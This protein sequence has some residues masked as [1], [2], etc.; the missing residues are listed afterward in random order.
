MSTIKKALSKQEWSKHCRIEL[1]ENII[2]NIFNN[3][4]PCWSKELLNLTSRGEKCCEMGCGT[5]QTSAYL[6]KYD[7]LMTS[8]DYSVDSVNLVNKLS[9]FLDVKINTMIF[10][11]TK[12]LP[13]T[14]N[15]FDTI[16]QCG[17]LEHFEKEE[18]ISLLKNW[19]KYSKR[20]ISMV[21]NG[22]SL[23]YRVGKKIMEDNN[24]WEYGLELPQF[25]LKQEFIV[26]GYKD[27]REYSIGVKHAFTFLPAE[28]DLRK[29]LERLQKEGYNLD[30]F[31]QGYLLVTIG[32][33]RE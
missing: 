33:K 27:I 11:V 4:V 16:F 14:E 22:A 2:K 28:H 32:E 21:P 25:S 13:F 6:A 23:P 30:D 20:M 26:A 7:R 8:I 10:D 19:S 29:S 12:K 24:M 1:A 31:G 3:N 15:E 5:G 9:Q 18:Q 17:L